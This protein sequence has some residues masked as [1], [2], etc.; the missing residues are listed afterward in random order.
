M[1]LSDLLAGR[2][3]PLPPPDSDTR[4]LQGPSS[5]WAMLQQPKLGNTDYHD[6][7]AFPSGWQQAPH[8]DTPPRRSLSDTL[9]PHAGDDGL[10]EPMRGD[11]F[12]A[13]YLPMGPVVQAGAASP[14]DSGPSSPSGAPSLTGMPQPAGTGLAH[15]L[16]RHYNGSADRYTTLDPVDLVDGPNVGSY[17]ANSPMMRVDTK[18]PARPPDGPMTPIQ[19]KGIQ[20]SQLSPG[21]PAGCVDSYVRCQEAVGNRRYDSGYT[22]SNCLHYCTT[23]GFWPYS[24]CPHG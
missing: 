2:W 23:Q 13:G 24:L 14:A 3:S 7:S 16:D 4:M 21:N 10:S 11:A 20:Q 1:T 15:N 12:Q 8:P 18:A 9:D 17:A 5:L 6:L 19:S 22:C